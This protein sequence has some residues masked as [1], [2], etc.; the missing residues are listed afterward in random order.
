M[1][2]LF[3]MI[4]SG[5]SLSEADAQCRNYYYSG[6]PPNGY[7][8]NASV[9]IGPSYGYAP[10]YVYTAPAYGY[11]YYGRP[12]YWNN[13]YNGGWGYRPNYY[14]GWNRGWGYGGGYYHHHCR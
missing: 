7:G 11:G 12:S 6:Y 1:V 4:L 8:Y 5:L 14:G 2:V 10:N 13:G 3:A 9:Y